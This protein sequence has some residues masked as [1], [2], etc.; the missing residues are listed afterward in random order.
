LRTLFCS[1]EKVNPSVF[2]QFRTLC[3]KTRGRVPLSRVV[4][5]PLYL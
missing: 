2:K 1:K 5:C 4:R 3:Q